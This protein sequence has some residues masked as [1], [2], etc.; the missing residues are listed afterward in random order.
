MVMNKETIYSEWMM[1]CCRVEQACFTATGG[2][3]E[4]QLMLHVTDPCMS[5]DEQLLALLDAYYAWIGGQLQG[6]QAVFKR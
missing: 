4:V 3:R 6:F 1:G 5:Y 2:G